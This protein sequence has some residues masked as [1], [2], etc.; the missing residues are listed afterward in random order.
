V[1]KNLRMHVREAAARAL[2]TVQ[3]YFGLFA[4]PGVPAHLGHVV[5]NAAP[6]DQRRYPDGRIRPWTR[7]ATSREQN[8]LAPENVRGRIFATSDP[9]GRPVRGG[10][11]LG[12]EQ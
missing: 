5:M 8:K 7:T 2:T 12:G 11:L 10:S 1:T 4:R 3:R 9:G 6:L